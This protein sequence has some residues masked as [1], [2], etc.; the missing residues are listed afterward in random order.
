MPSP[1]QTGNLQFKQR[2]Y[3]FPMNENSGGLGGVSFL[4][5]DLIEFENKALLYANVHLSEGSAWVRKGGR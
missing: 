3:R 2:E 4:S 1:S 5:I